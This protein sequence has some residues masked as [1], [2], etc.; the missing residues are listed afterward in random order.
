[1]K[2]ASS[3]FSAS[4]RK[5]SS[6]ARSSVLARS[7]QGSRLVLDPPVPT[8]RRVAAPHLRAPNRRNPFVLRTESVPAGCD[9]HADPSERLCERHQRCDEKGVRGG[10]FLRKADIDRL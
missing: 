6:L 7:L 3:I 8:P 9:G 5:R 1:M 2:N 10:V 4:N